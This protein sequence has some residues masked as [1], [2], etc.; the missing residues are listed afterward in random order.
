MKILSLITLLV[1]S[2]KN[3][4]EENKNFVIYQSD[5]KN[6]NLEFY[7]KDDKSQILKSIGNLKKYV[8]EENKELIFAMNGGMFTPDNHPKGIFIQNY[9]I[10]TELDTLSGEG[11][12]Y[13]N[14]NGVFYINENNEAGIATTKNY[15]KYCINSKFATQS[16]PMLIISGKINPL[17]QKNSKNLNIRNGVGISENGKMIFAMSKKEINFYDFA[18]FFQSMDCKNAL[19]LD[20]FVSRTYLPQQNWIQEDGNFGV[21]IGITRRK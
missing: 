16:G 12:F 10:I 5:I 7:W 15:N 20:G 4:N 18:A 1:F 17:F 2:C 11:N 3:A 9:K 8:N 21:I 19:Y 14:P 6:E 13:M